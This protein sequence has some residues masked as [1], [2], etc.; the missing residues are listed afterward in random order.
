MRVRIGQ[1][2]KYTALRR[3]VFWTGT[4]RINISLE[5][6]IW[7]NMMRQFSL[8]LKEYEMLRSSNFKDKVLQ[9]TK[10]E[11]ENMELTDKNDGDSDQ[12]SESD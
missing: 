11:T 3:H 2:N 4:R 9:L 6:M 8:L 1:K 12:D 7:D 5:V 10:N